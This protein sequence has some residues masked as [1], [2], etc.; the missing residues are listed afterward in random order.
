M[1]LYAGYVKTSKFALTSNKI[2]SISFPKKV[3]KKKNHV[4]WG[5]IMRA[6]NQPNLTDRSNS[7]EKPK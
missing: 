1:H 6:K 2:L 7:F 4:E 5:M 3:K